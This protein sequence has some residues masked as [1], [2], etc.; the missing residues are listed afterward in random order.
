MTCAHAVALFNQKNIKGSVTFHQ[1]RNSEFVLV[2]IN[3]YDLPPLKERA[4]HI[5]EYGDETDGCIA[6]GGHWNPYNENHGSIHLRTRRHAGDLINNICPD[7]NGKFYYAYKD[8][9]LKLH[10]NINESIIGRSV[11]IHD[12][13]DDLG[14]GGKINGKVV[15]KRVHA[16]SLRT[17]NASSRMACAII[18]HA[19]PT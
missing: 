17:G 16:E 14:Q 15:N 6:L 2:I 12:G 3:L 5:H 13:Q 7:R 4:I 9:L 8:F 18:G 1:C 10:G 19:N 11:V